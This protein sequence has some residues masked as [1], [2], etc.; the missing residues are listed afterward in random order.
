MML[1]LAIVTQE[2]P[3]WASLVQTVS[4]EG[5][6]CV[7]HHD[8]STYMTRLVDEQTALVLVNGDGVD[9]WR[10]WVVTPKVNP[11]TRRIP[12][13]LVSESADKR[14]EALTSGADFHL[15]PAELA[16]ELP[17]LVAVHARVPA[18]KLVKQMEDECAEP[19]P[20]EGLEGIQRFNSGEYYKQH[21]LFEALWVDEVGPVRD[22]YRAILQ[23]GVA[24][25]QVTRGNQRGALKMLMRS[26]QWLALLPDE[27]R[28]VDIKQLREDS[29]RVRA[30]LERVKDIAEFDMTL[31]QP[32]KMRGK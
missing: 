19:L 4:K 5:F 28:G 25:Y 3:T 6:T 31:L 13:V 16:I 26:V 2:T 24:Y 11:A 14:R 30:E 10:F 1:T 27:C 29:Y 18:L 9:D 21:D 12:I 22:L 8:R 20:A 15:S 23:V 7:E 32:V 17:R